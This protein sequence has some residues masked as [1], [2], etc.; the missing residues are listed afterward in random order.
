MLIDFLPGTVVRTRWKANGGQTVLQRSDGCV[1]VGTIPAGKRGKVIATR[2][3]LKDGREDDVLV[4]FSET[5]IVGRWMHSIYLRRI[6]VIERLGN[7][8]DD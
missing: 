7:L 2:S 1:A 6:D 5:G 8:A 4:D 3:P